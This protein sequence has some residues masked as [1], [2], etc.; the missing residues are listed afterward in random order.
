MEKVE[1]ALK[2]LYCRSVRQYQDAGLLVLHLP[3]DRPALPGLVKQ[4]KVPAVVCNQHR[5]PLRR[6]K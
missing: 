5:V 6:G 3:R 2:R 1:K 4:A